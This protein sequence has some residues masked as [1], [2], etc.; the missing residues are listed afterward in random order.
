MAFF[1]NLD[2]LW[3]K[4]LR[5]RV[6]F[7]VFYDSMVS[8][9]V[10]KSIV[11][12]APLFRLGGQFHICDGLNTRF[13]CDSWLVDDPFL[14]YTMQG[15]H[16][17]V[18]YCRACDYC[19][20]NAWRSYELVPYLPASVTELFKL[21]VLNDVGTGQDMIYWKDSA[22]GQCTFRNTY[23]LASSMDDSSSDSSWDRI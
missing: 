12:I 4:I 23:M 11:S 15:I 7:D 17:T 14:D 16:E 22:S 20:G 2:A 18:I 6:G 1:E 9:H 5:G 8:S 13:W 10:W 3:V 21:A 19:D